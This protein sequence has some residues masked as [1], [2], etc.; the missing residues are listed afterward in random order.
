MHFCQQIFKIEESGSDIEDHQFSDTPPTA[1]TKLKAY[2]AP[3]ACIV[4][5]WMKF[6]KKRRALAKTLASENVFVINTSFT[7]KFGISRSLRNFFTS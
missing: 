7:T 2:W 1:V 4:A 3:S 6:R 5:H